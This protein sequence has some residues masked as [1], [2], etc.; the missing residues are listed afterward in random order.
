MREHCTIPMRVCDYC[1]ALFA[2][3]LRG[4]RVGQRFCSRACSGHGKR[5]R[6][7]ASPEDFAARFWSK[8]EK[9]DGCWF[10]TSSTNAKGYGSVVCDGKTELAHRVAWLLTHGPIPA[11]MFVC[12]NCPGG[13]QP[14]CCRPAHLWLGTAKDNSLDMVAKG[15][16]VL[17]RLKGERHYR[18]H[19]T[20]KDVLAIRQRRAEGEKLARIGADFGIG[21][22]AV[23]SIANH[24]RWKHIT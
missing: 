11:G 15:R 7:P 4:L 16:H 23:W 17:P 20:D 3:D 19:L 12:H 13:D 8:V 14:A 5:K 18:T 6:R 2:V 24:Q 9:T 1:G 21:M 22:W 10:W